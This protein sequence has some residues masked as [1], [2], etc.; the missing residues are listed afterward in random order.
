MAF[1]DSNVSAYQGCTLLL[2]FLWNPN[3][4]AVDLTGYGAHMQ[5]RSYPG[6]PDLEL[7]LSTSNYNGGVGNGF[8]ALGDPNPSDGTI[9]INAPAAL[10]TLAPALYRYDIDLFSGSTTP[11]I[12]KVVTGTLK[13]YPTV[14]VDVGE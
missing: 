14:T 2:Q 13:I 8:I 7:D 5:V 3:G 1:L 12:T 11:I 10:M 9:N 6:A 4:V